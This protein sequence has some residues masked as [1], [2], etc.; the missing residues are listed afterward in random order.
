MVRW[1]SCPGLTLRRSLTTLTSWLRWSFKGSEVSKSCQNSNILSAGGNTGRWCYE[2]RLSGAKFSRLWFYNMIN[3][4]SRL[5][6]PGWVTRL[7]SIFWAGWVYPL[8]DVPSKW[9]HS[10]LD[11]GSC[12]HP[13]QVDGSRLRKKKAL[14]KAPTNENALPKNWSV[15]LLNGKHAWPISCRPKT[16]T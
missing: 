2:G 7:G 3:C 12:R 11:L 4:L 6:V 10:W 14:A 9:Q 16:I 13:L 15:K 5:G 8:P 1:F